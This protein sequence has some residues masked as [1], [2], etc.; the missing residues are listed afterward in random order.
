MSKVTHQKIKRPLM[1]AALD[2]GGS[3][4]KVIYENTNGEVKSLVMQPEVATVPIE[5]IKNYEKDSLGS[6]EPEN[7][8]WIYLPLAP[9]VQVVGYLAK[10]RYYANAALGELKYE[11]G[12][13]KTLAAVWA[14]K[15]KLQLPARLQV[16]LAVLLPPGEFEDKEQFEG[17]LRNTLLNYLTPTGQMNVE[18]AMFKC[19]P[20][21]AGIYL[22][23][24]KKVGAAL[25]Q[26]VCALA[27]IGYRNAS[28][29]ISNRGMVKEGK[30]SDLGMVRMMEKV[31]AATSGQ[32]LER[33]TSVIAAAGADIDH[34]VLQQLTRSKTRE[35]QAT[36]IK[37]L[38]NAIRKARAE[39]TAMLTS[40][41]DNVLPD[42]VD[43]IVFCGGTADY[44]I[45]ELNE[46]YPRTP[47]S[48]N[49]SI[50][51]P[52]SVDISGLGSRLCDVYSLFLYFHKVVEAQLRT[53]PK[54]GKDKIEY[55]V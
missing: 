19:L 25:K 48:W 12:V 43:E 40:W 42:T 32:T 55:A 20:E 46:H 26:R 33:L 52:V 14:I 38:D 5:S 29:L 30:T 16:A 47:L 2:F 23:H 15:E 17:V 35:G 11:R 49:A 39:Y 10:E 44:L 22:M 8:A 31:V 3:A 41:L 54:S 1:I 45:K 53:L 50:E 9:V 13:Y 28:V 4:T 21:G 6:T 18:L 37:K 7:R 34:R 51:I 36:E 24:E 27:M